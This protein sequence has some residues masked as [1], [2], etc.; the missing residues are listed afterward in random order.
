MM[1]SPYDIGFGPWSLWIG[2]S[3]VKLLILGIL[4]W[5]VVHLLRHRDTHRGQTAG[6]RS[7][8]LHSSSG[9]DANGDA[10]TPK[11]E[12]STA[13]DDSHSTRPV[14]DVGNLHGAY[15]LN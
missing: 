7:R 1:Q 8:L 13:Q 9:R 10:P 11:P 12:H 2:I 4:A 5:S 3:L 14:R 6:I 15:R